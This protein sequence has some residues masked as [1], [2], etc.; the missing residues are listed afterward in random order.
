MAK[1]EPMPRLLIFIMIGFGLFVTILPS[2]FW[3]RSEYYEV[4]PRCAHK[5]EVQ[6]W[7]IPFTDKPY[8]QHFTIRDTTLSK[9]VEDLQLV[10]DHDHLWLQAHGS[11]PGGRVIYGEGFLIA[12]GLITP[13]VGEFV[14]LLDRY[15]DEE[16][17]AYWIARITH[18]EHSYVVRNV[19]D[20]CAG[21]SYE[22][23]E[24][25]NQRL[26]EVAKFEIS[27]QRYRLGIFIDE[28]ETRTP[29]RLLYQRPPR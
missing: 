28:P 27:Q 13:S 14:R 22:N 1:S 10:D 3:F 11:G 25:F 6:E 9:T 20:Q 15:S 21:R 19:A 29:P 18:P 7:L 5:R 26:E 24:T 2:I 4:C 16:Q 23:A 8:Y 12:H 17:M